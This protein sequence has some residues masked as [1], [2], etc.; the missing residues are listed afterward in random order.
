[1]KKSIITTIITTM[2]SFPVM[3]ESQTPLIIET[4]YNEDVSMFVGDYPND[5]IFVR[6]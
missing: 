4:D 2:L 3:A 6:Q 1:M 5:N